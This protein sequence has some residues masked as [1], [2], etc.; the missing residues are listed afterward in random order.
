MNQSKVYLITAML[1]FGSIGLFVRGIELSSVQIAMVRGIIGSLFILA[2][3]LVTKQKISW[4]AIRPNLILLICS[5]VAIG[6]NWILLFEAY[7]YT[8]ISN[9]TLSYYFA[10]VFVMFLSP[11]LLKEK[12]TLKK[13]IG[14]GCAVAGM[15]LIVGIESGPGKNHLLGI[16]YGLMAAGLYATDILINKFIKNLPGLE[17]TIVQLLAASLVLLPY[18][19]ITGQLQFAQID[20]KSLVLLLIVSVIHTGIAYILYFSAIKNLKGQTIAV[21]CYIDPISA[22]IMSNIFLG[23]QLTFIQVLGGILIL[24]ATFFNEFNL[25]NAYKRG[26]LWWRSEKQ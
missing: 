20:S 5:G 18:V 4:K 17:T 11:F 1:I 15:F 23:E 19:I 7:R 8:T 16:T 21:L 10:P 22:I 6:L 24:G 2:V 14:I 9:A 3:S 25:K 26:I 13:I 12:L